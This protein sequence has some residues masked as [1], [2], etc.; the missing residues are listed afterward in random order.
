A[1]WRKICRGLAHKNRE[2][3]S[4]NLSLRSG[5]CH[6]TTSRTRHCAAHCRKCNLCFSSDTAFD[7]HITHEGDQVFHELP[8]SMRYETGKRVGHPKFE[9]AVGLCTHQ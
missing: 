2:G 1:C 4:R 9:E 3:V 8:G 6:M 5:A 7:L